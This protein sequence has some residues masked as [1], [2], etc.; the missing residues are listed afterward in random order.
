M[1]D[2]AATGRSELILCQTE[3]GRTRIQCRFGDETVCLTQKLMAAFLQLGTVNDHPKA[4]FS[5]GEL[6]REATIRTLR[7]V[8]TRW[9]RAPRLPS[10][11]GGLA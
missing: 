3:D 2:D 8:R 7:I 9:G 5:E 6:S 10:G 11:R 1:T 4:I